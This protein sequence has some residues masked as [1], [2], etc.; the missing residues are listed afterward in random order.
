MPRNLFLYFSCLLLISSS[1]ANECIIAKCGAIQQSLTNNINENI[2]AIESINDQNRATQTFQSCPESMS[3]CAFS[4]A[5]QKS[6]CY[7]EKTAFDY[8]SNPGESC[9]EADDCIT[10][11]CDFGICRG[12]EA[13]AQCFQD[14]DCDMGLFC[15]T[16][17]RKCEN[18][19]QIGE[20]CDILNHKCVNWAACFNNKCVELLS[21][22]VGEAITGENISG[23]NPALCSA[24]TLFR[25]SK[26]ELVCAEGY[27]LSGPIERHSVNDT[28]KY[29]LNAEDGVKI[30][31]FEPQCGLSKSGAF[32]CPLGY[33]DLQEQL[34]Q[35]RS[36]LS[37]GP[38]C[39]ISSSLT[40]DCNNTKGIEGRESAL[41][42]LYLTK[43]LKGIDFSQQSVRIRNNDD[44]VKKMLTADYWN[45]MTKDDTQETDACTSLHFSA[46][47]AAVV[48]LTLF[49]EI[50]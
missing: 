45:H 33:G 34:S 7:K 6:Y 43:N 25:N 31:E 27:K 36:F 5:N 41:A 39:P 1:F 2:C 50:L 19:R 13:G 35:L 3:S 16:K 17:E 32:Y 38:I 49:L 14:P 26:N 42:A 12:N 11:V 29:T 44:C 28:C 9:A 10:G 48:V 8:Y 15:N 47:Y 40:F 4:G 20:T 23:S 30:V 46:L 24:L 21:L 18:Y 37:K 22:P